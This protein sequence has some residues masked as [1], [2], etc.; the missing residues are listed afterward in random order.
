MK[1]DTRIPELQALAERQA[2]G[3]TPEITRERIPVVFSSAPLVSDVA[4]NLTIMNDLPVADTASLTLL[5]SIQP[6]LAAAQ[7]ISILQAREVDHLR[8]RSASIL[9]KWYRQAILDEAEAWSL[10]E[11]RLAKVEQGV[12]RVEHAKMKEMIES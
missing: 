1:S 6:G 2:E 9:A 3:I 11:A 8:H 10:I 7:S 5:N 12:R 4:S